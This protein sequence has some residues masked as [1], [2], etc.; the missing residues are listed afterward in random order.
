MT[1]SRASLVLAA[2]LAATPTYAQVFKG[3]HS[4]VCRQ[5]ED[6]LPPCVR[7]VVASRLHKLIVSPHFYKSDYW[8]WSF[9]HKGLT[10][11]S[12]PCPLRNTCAHEMGHYYD[13]GTGLSKREDFRDALKADF[14]G[15]DKKDAKLD[16]YLQDPQEA[17][18][19]LFATEMRGEDYYREKPHLKMSVFP[20]TQQV[21]RRALCSE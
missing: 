19:E 17:A 9:D 11:I 14:T 2:L 8:A 6:D 20:R 10:I 12:P 21:L 13:W 15:M 4:D 16:D 18:A 3:P 1:I 7:A 5:V